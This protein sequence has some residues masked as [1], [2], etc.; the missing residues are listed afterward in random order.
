MLTTAGTWKQQRRG[1]QSV[2]LWQQ[3][4]AAK[5]Y[6]ARKRV[7]LQPRLGAGRIEVSV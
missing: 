6:W 5:M 3:E 4:G 2:L 1:D 7:S